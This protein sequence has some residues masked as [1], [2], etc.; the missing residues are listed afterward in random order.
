M[1]ESYINTPKN[2]LFN[3]YSCY[4]Q[5][6]LV[7][8]FNYHSIILKK[9]LV[10]TVINAYQAYAFN[11]RKFKLADNIFLFKY[12]NFLHT[13]IFCEDSYSQLGN[14]KENFDNFGGDKSEDATSFQQFNVS[15][16]H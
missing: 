13:Q 14:S 8:Y 10:V 16:V 1:I 9:L 6:M 7:S 2:R 15:E 5:I 11:F 12:I 4:F 3:E